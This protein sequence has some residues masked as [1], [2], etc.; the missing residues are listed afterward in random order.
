MM[1]SMTSDSATPT[2]EELSQFLSRYCARLLGAGATCM[3]IEMNVNRIAARYGK[4]VDMAIMPRHIHL[5]IWE[6]GKGEAVTS[7]ATVRHSAISFNLN[8]N[9]S[10]LSWRI[11]DR[12]LDFAEAKALF[13]K[14]IRS[15]RQNKWIVLVLVAFAN[16]A[17][18]RLFCGDWIASAVV[19]VATLAGYFLK[20]LLLER[21][22]D[23]R[24]VFIACAFVSSVLGASDMLFHLGATPEVAIATSVLYLVPGIPFINSFSDLLYRHYL[25][26]FSRFMDALVLTCCLSIGLC[27]GMLLMHA[28]MF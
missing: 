22:V 19:W 1:T 6:E 20:L 23:A 8:T 15:D 18:C 7:I 4:R 3:R 11:A 9:L 5:H 25:C 13:D 28:G 27:A 2:S 17:F 10:K 24:A 16:A 26:A 21:E 12:C 14:Y